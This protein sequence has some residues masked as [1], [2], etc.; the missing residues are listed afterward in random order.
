MSRVE[1]RALSRKRD[2]R[3]S[4]CDT[5]DMRRVLL[6]LSSLLTLLA[7]L[8][9]EAQIRNSG[10][11]PYYGVE[12]EPHALWQWTG[13]EWAWEDGIGF[14]LRVSIPILENGPV[15]TLNN[16]LAVTFGFDWA[17]FDGDC[18]AGGRGVDCDESDTWVPVAAQWN[19]FITDV[20]SLFPEVGLGFRNAVRD[21]DFCDSAACDDE[22]LEVHFALWFG[23]RFRIAA[24]IALVLR[25]G[26]PSMSFGVSF[27]L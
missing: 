27:L 2:Q 4:A 21:T 3:R 8:P 5:E 18:V 19:F 12:L 13:D 10:T 24:P 25:L 26:T 1:N 17:H 23:A 22:D 16:N 7:S 9:A 15:K 20:V 11:H 14:G 6:A